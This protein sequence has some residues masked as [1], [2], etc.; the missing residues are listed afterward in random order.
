MKR[1]SAGCKAGVIVGDYGQCPGPACSQNSR[2]FVFLASS[3][4]R[5]QSIG[6][7]ILN[8]IG[9]HLLVDVDC[10]P[11]EWTEHFNQRDEY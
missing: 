6:Q 8:S 1:A 2:Q 5:T 10:L 11:G 9:E 3:Q 7:R 4:R